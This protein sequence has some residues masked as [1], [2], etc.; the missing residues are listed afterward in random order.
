MNTG[1]FARSLRTFE[2]LGKRYFVPVVLLFGMIKTM[3]LDSSR[4]AIRSLLVVI[5]LSLG[6]IGITSQAV[7][8]RIK[9]Y[10]KKEYLIVVNAVLLA[11]LLLGLEDYVILYRPFIAFIS[12]FVLFV[13]LSSDSKKKSKVHLVL[14]ILQISISVMV[15][16][17]VYSWLTSLLLLI[18]AVITLKKSEDSKGAFLRVYGVIALVIFGMTLYRIFLYNPLEIYYGS[19]TDML[20]N[21]MV[22]WASI[23][24]LYSLSSFSGDS[25]LAMGYKY[26]ELN[27]VNSIPAYILCYNGKALFIIYMLL[28]WFTVLM[29]IGYFRWS[30]HKSKDKTR[31]AIAFFG[32]LVFVTCVFETTV[33]L[34]ASQLLY[35]KFLAVIFVLDHKILLMNLEETEDES[36]Q[37]RLVRNTVFVMIFAALFVKVYTTIPYYDSMNHASSS[38]SKKTVDVKVIKDGKMKPIQTVAN[39]SASKTYR[40]IYEEDLKSSR[41][42]R[43][44][45]DTSAGYYDSLSG[46]EILSAEKQG[47]LERFNGLLAMEKKSNPGTWTF[48]NLEGKSLYEAPLKS[49]EALDYCSYLCECN[50][51]SYMILNLQEIYRNTAG[52]A[53]I[54]KVPKQYKPEIVKGEIVVFIDNQEKTSLVYVNERKKCE[55]NSEDS[56]WVRYDNSWKS[57]E[58]ALRICDIKIEGRSYQDN[59]PNSIVYS[60]KKENG[61][62]YEMDGFGEDYHKDELVLYEDDIDD[63]GAFVD[64][65]GLRNEYEVPVKPDEEGYRWIYGLLIF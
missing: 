11:C 48:K 18:T 41:I 44:S 14:D 7:K 56:H 54:N 38:D 55:G 35:L 20:T 12:I 63:T 57:R 2:D 60:F 9:K 53:N 27:L 16:I 22:R 64:E 43:F 59:V 8:K 5:L 13:W 30:H 61:K 1:L 50:D 6:Y 52:H 51:G 34:S 26:L 40:L 58:I 25:I 24:K 29:G 21:Q 17:G 36:K 49:V 62:T 31:D 33:M 39:G 65:V 19:L 15:L 46:K 23:T 28:E 42:V 10:Y 32:L 3:V 4:Y 47:G 45:N 37:R